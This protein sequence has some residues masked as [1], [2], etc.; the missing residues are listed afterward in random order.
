MP[1]VVFIEHNGTVH[2]VDV[3]NG[4]SIMQAAVSRAV[5]GIE[6]DCGGLCACATCHV[7]IPDK[8]KDKC[9]EPEELEQGILDFAFDVNE[10]S[11]LGCQIEITDELD[12]ITVNMPERQ[13]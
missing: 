10:N 1:R 2:E 7:Y 4:T 12:G 8:W 5:P 11:R 13:Y 3:A 9:G 6:G